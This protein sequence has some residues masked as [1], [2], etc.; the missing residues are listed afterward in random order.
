[1]RLLGEYAPKTDEGTIAGNAV[2]VQAASVPFTKLLR[3]I[4]LVVFIICSK[5]ISVEN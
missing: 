5:F 2:V 4:P 1:M 3:V